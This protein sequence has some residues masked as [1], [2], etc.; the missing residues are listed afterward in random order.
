MAR[1]ELAYS[2][3]TYG[4]R[5]GRTFRV[6]W[7]E[8]ARRERR[9]AASQAVRVG[10]LGGRVRDRK[11]AREERQDGEELHGDVEV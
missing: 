3:A 6:V 2:S 8:P 7:M 1:R 4:K 5:D 10:R 11:E 9:K